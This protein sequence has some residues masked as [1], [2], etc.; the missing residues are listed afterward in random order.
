MPHLQ[1]VFKLLVFSETTCPSNN[2]IQQEQ[3]TWLTK[4]V[5][6]KFE[7]LHH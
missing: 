5:T 2:T 4:Y 3:N 1:P 7:Y 6:F